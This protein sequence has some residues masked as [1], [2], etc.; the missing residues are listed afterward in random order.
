MK[1]GDRK[2]AKEE[3][4]KGKDYEA[5]ADEIALE[6]HTL[7]STKKN[8]RKDPEAI[9]YLLSQKLS[10]PISTYAATKVRRILEMR[11]TN[12]SSTGT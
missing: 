4:L 7:P 11:K 3:R 2:A 6:Y 10:K 1:T 12:I 8:D 9:A 5:Y